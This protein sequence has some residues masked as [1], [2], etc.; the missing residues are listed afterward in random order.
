MAVN[1]TTRPKLGRSCGGR[2]AIMKYGVMLPNVGPMADMDFL[3]RAAGRA[4]ELGYD[5]VFLSDHIVIPREMRSA[6]PY[7]TDGRFPLS[8]G[9]RILEPVTAL[10][11]LAGVTGSLRLG[12]SVLVLPYRHPVLNAKM[13]GTLD[14]ISGGR[15][16]VGAGVG[17]LA[18][19]FA[20]LDAD[21]EARG[22]VAEEHIAILRALWTEPEA[23]FAGAHYKVAGL[24][25][26]PAPVSRPH[27]PIWVGGTGPRALR[28]AARLGDGWHGVR[29][30]PGDI[31]GAVSALARHRGRAGASMEGFEIS[32]RAGL[33]IADGRATGAC[34][35]PLRGTP[36]QVAS[37]L[38]D[39][40]G[41]GLTYLVVEPRAATPEQLMGQLERFSGLAQPGLL[42]RPAAVDYQFAAGDEG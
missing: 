9:D 38:A 13:L 25:M 12:L 15:L 29:Q 35:T 18:E 33:D 8:A 22:A 26:T 3:A 4:E 14:A 10:A 24:G 41:A 21:F 16:I 2:E 32:L 37:D 34:R 42:R 11:Y 31:A 23:D 28:R 20:A 30:S 5:G 19:E 27:P 1:M 39:Y 40:A 17:W 6:Y 36:E 7:R